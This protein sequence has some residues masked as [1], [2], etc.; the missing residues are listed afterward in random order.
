MKQKKLWM[1]VVIAV[2]CLSWLTSCVENVDNP[3]GGSTGYS[4]A[5]FVASDRHE[6]GNGN[7]LTAM[8]AKAVRIGPQADPKPLPVLQQLGESCTPP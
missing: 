5:I 2:C 7:N 3:S 1:R 8:R 4:T 6:T